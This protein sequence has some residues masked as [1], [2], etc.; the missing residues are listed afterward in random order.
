MNEQ[1]PGGLEPQQFEVIN[2]RGWSDPSRR[3]N[4]EKHFRTPLGA[5][6]HEFGADQYS[7]ICAI[8]VI[9]GGVT[10]E[11]NREFASAEFRSVC[12]Q[13]F[14]SPDGSFSSGLLFLGASSRQL[15]ERVQPYFTRRINDVLQNLQVPTRLG[16]HA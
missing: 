13:Q 5:Y 1:Y 8:G 3:D 15:A 14:D 9:A 7:K 11:L 10:I 2:T 16:E 12:H 6:A 4:F